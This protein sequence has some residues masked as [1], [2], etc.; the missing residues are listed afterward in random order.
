[1]AYNA[2]QYPVHDHGTMQQLLQQWRPAASANARPEERPAAGVRTVYHWQQ[3]H[4]REHDRLYTAHAVPAPPVAFTGEQRAQQ[5]AFPGSPQRAATARVSANPPGAVPPPNRAEHV[6][7]NMKRRALHASLGST[8]V[9]VEAELPHPLWQDSSL[10]THS[11]RQYRPREDDGKVYTTHL[12]P[13]LRPYEAVFVQRNTRLAST[14]RS[15]SS[16]AG[17]TR[18]RE[19]KRVHHYTK[20]ALPPLNQATYKK[21]LADTQPLLHPSMAS[22]RMCTD[23]QWLEAL[24]QRK[25]NPYD[26]DVHA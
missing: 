23:N 9:G 4:Y 21:Y 10:S 16:G 5:Q 25:V 14:A 19:R 7:A 15:A 24:L 17:S 6:P 22:R 26:K 18:E 12:H 13:P 3:P 8:R 2:L 20:P 1:M 11:S